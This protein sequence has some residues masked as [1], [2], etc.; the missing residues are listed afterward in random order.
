MLSHLN[1]WQIVQL[2]ELIAHLSRTVNMKQSKLNSLKEAC[3]NIA[4]GY[5]VG[6]LTQ[7]ILY[8]LY[9]IHIAFTTNL[10]LSFWFTIVAIA[11]S[12]F[13]RRYY[14]YQLHKNNSVA[15]QLTT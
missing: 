4:I 14:N 6:M 2:V 12:Y 1:D 7:L 10:A 3:T 15:Q 5:V 9:G 13:V 8:P 11:R